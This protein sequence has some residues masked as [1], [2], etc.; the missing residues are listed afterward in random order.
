MDRPQV[1]YW[2]MRLTRGGPFVGA[3]I[4]WVQTTHEPGEPDN[5]ME[6]SP[7]L[8]ALI[9]DEVVSIDRVWLSRGEPISEAEYRYLCASVDYA[10]KH[11]PGAPEADPTKRIDL[12]T[13]QPVYRRRQA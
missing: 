10:M 13:A 6:R 8:V 3:C 11:D 4:K 2:R 5:R 1:G 9:S 7:F 12:A